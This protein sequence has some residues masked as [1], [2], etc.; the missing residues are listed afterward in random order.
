MTSCNSRALRGRGAS[1]ATGV[2]HGAILRALDKSNGPKKMARLSIGI[3]RHFPYEPET[4]LEHPEME[5]L[6]EGERS[7]DEFNGLWYIK[8]TIVW[9][10]KAVS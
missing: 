4:I 2:A 8:N 9:L 3:L 10:I 6:H 7:K 5:P 1:C